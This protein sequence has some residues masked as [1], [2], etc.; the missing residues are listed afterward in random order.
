MG[1][2]GGE[3]VIGEW[4]STH[5]LRLQNIVIGWIRTSSYVWKRHNGNS[6]FFLIF[7]KIGMDKKGWQKKDLL[8]GGL[9]ILKTNEIAGKY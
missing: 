6:H 9:L 7:S 3:G 5:G 4:E 8:W 2:E 1:E